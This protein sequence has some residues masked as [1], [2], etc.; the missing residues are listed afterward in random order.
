MTQKGLTPWQQ[1]TVIYRAQPWRIAAAAVALTIALWQLSNREAIWALIWCNVA[2]QVLVLG[3][4]PQKHHEPALVADILAE[5][6][7]EHD[8]L[9][10]K[11]RQLKVSEVKKIALD[12]LDDEYAFIDFPFNIYRAVAMRFPIA[13]LPALTAWLDAN[14]PDAEIIK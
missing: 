12:K 6:K 13:Q 11:Q 3:V 2:I 5:L 8:M 7:L 9:H 1:L 14:L 10:V 4:F